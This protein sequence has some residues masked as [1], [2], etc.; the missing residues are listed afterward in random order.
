MYDYL[1]NTLTRDYI[2]H[3]TFNVNKIEFATMKRY[4]NR[5]CSPFSKIILHLALSKG[6]ALLNI[7]WIDSLEVLFIH[8][9]YS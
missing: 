8:A 9:V 3:L 2:V 7:K 1:F 4:F 5:I 6:R